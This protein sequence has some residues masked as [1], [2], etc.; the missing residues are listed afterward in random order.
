MNLYIELLS[1]VVRNEIY[2]SYHDQSITSQDIETCQLVISDLQKNNPVVLDTYPHLKDAKK[3]ADIIN[4]TKS[5]KPVHTYVNEKGTKNLIELCETVI[6]ENIDGSFVEVGTLRG[7][8]GILMAGIIQS[9]GVDK[10]LYIFDSFAG[11]NTTNTKDSLFDR[12]V[13][14]RYR[15]WFTQHQFNCEC[16]KSEVIENFKK[17]DLDSIPRLMEGWIPDC[18]SNFDE[19]ISCLR[20][21]VDWY[22]ATLDTL[23]NLYD[24]VEP[25]GYIIIDDYK[26][27]G[28]KKA[29]HEFFDLKGISPLIQ[30]ACEQS[31]II[32]W[33]KNHD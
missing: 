4:Y 6:N 17:Y 30:H 29:I 9:T 19:K 31:G 12:E 1:K 11:L 22:Q 2:L 14:D 15:T 27:E 21:D 20:I 8:L 5:S 26:L 16:S 13:W 3:F 33:K 25:G 10:N 7:G 28:C 18:F 32:Y 23:L 24:L